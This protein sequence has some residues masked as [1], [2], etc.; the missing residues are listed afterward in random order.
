MREKIARQPVE[1][2]RY[3]GKRYLTLDGVEEL[4][5]LISEEIEKVENPYLY[6]GSPHTEYDIE[7]NKNHAAFKECC[8]KILVLLGG[9]MKEI[10]C[11]VNEAPKRD[12][13]VSLAELCMKHRR[14]GIEEG[15][16]QVEDYHTDCFR[17]DMAKVMGMGRREGMKEVVKW[18][19]EN[20]LAYMSNSVVEPNITI[21]P[22]DWQAFKESKG[23]DENRKD[24]QETEA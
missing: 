1:T 24:N 6:F 10:W 9:I 2:H 17:Q 20:N 19:E 22:D 18:L 14:E 23:L 16:R 4:L 21:N 5:T 3:D 12:K 11:K 15:K 13:E 8:Q 7:S